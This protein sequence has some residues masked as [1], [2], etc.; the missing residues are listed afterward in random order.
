MDD[1]PSMA[2]MKDQ[3]NATPTAITTDATQM[4]QMD[5]PTSGMMVLTGLEGHA[6]EVV[7]METMIEHHDQ[8][9]HMSERLLVQTG[10]EGHQE[11]R[12]FAQRVIDN[13]SAEIK[14]MESMIAERQ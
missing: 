11:L 3:M 13:Q 1:Q 9:I 8:A 5:M 2:W 14:Q 6:Y 4:P 10:S 7:F 12:A